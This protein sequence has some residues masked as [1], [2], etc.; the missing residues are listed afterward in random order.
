M[1]RQLGKIST[2]VTLLLI[3]SFWLWLYCFGP[4]DALTQHAMRLYQQSKAWLIHSS[5]QSVT[6]SPAE[7]PTP[8][9]TAVCAA[10]LPPN[11][12]V[13]QTRSASGAQMLGAV[14]LVN[15]LR[16][17]VRVQFLAASD[18]VDDVFLY[19]LQSAIIKLPQGNYQVEAE[20][21][22]AW[23][24]FDEGFV[25]GEL[26]ATLADLSLNSEKALTLKLTSLDGSPQSVMLSISR[27][28]GNAS[29][30]STDAVEGRGELVLYRGEYGHYFIDGTLNRVPA[31]FMVDTGASM[32]AISERFAHSIGITQCQPV[33]VSTANGVVNACLA[34]AHEL[35]IGTFKLHNVEITYGSGISDDAYLLGMTVLERFKMVQQGDVMI[36]T[37]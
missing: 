4:V 22:T 36:L 21:G 12:A 17:M 19:P 9:E 35:S 16:H 11:G 24:N 34:T 32:V 3:G 37:R 28:I 15:T 30:Y 18:S 25:D 7:L 6:A 8:A 23:C 29:T 13:R 14:Y 10:T 33:R 5:S 31:R 2:V 26:V 27:A 20:V 1:Y